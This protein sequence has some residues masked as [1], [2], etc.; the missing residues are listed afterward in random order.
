MTIVRGI[1]PPWSPL[2]RINMSP[3]NSNVIQP[4]VGVRSEWIAAAAEFIKRRSHTLLR[5]GLRL[6][7][8]DKEGM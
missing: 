8:H 2:Y 3:D 5:R 6:I 1:R 7:T 4:P